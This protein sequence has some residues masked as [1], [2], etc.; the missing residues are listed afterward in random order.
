MLDPEK[1]AELG[2]LAAIYPTCLVSAVIEPNLTLQLTFEDGAR[3]DVPQD[4][5]YEAWQIVARIRA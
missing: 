1:R 4:R 5:E 2:P 3:I